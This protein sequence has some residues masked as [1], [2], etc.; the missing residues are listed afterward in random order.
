MRSLRHDSARKWARIALKCGLLLTD[1]KLWS[2]IGDQ[3]RDRASDIGDEV[4]RR[5]EDTADRIHEAHSALQ[6]RGHWLATAASFVGGVGIGVG[7]GMLVAPV[8]G[9][10]ARTVLRNKVVGMK[11]KATDVASGATGT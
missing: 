3:L 5:Y 1:T 2:S 6:G 10:E 11:N 7:L 8:S 9:E 4:Q